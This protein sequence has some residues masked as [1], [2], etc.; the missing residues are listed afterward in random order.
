MQHH[1]DATPRRV[2][3]L[4]DFRVSFFFS[5]QVLEAMIVGA[6]G[7]GF[8]VAALTLS[9]PSAPPGSGPPCM[10]LVSKTEAPHSKIRPF[11]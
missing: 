5:P 9:M 7:V 8:F 1:R 3:T 11:L 4:P 2:G 6:P 10:G